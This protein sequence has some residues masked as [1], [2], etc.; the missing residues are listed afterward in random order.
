MPYRGDIIWFFVLVE[1]L[2]M[3]PFNSIEGWDEIN[4][5][6]QRHWDGL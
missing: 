4:A 1:K 5:F 3:G 6:I 2:D